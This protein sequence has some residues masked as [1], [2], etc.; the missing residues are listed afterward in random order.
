MGL[1]EGWDPIKIGINPEI[2][3]AGGLLL[4]WH[5]VFV[6]IGIAL[7]VWVAVKMADRVGFIEDDSYTIALVAVVAGIIGARVLFVAENWNLFSDKP[8]DVFRINEGGISIYGALIGGVV[9]AMLYNQWGL[10]VFAPV[11]SPVMF[12]WVVL[13][14]GLR[15]PLVALGAGLDAI[16]T[17]LRNG[18]AAP[19]LPIRAGLDAAAFGMILGQGIGRIGDIIN[20]EHLAKTTDLPWAVVYTHANSPSFGLAPQ[21]PAVAYEFLGDLIIFGLL[22]LFWRFYKRD[23]LVFFT[24]AF[25]YSAMRVG[26]S[27]L[28]LDKQVLW[29]F[30]MAQVIALVVIGISILGFAYCMRQPSGRRKVE[31]VLAPRPA[32]GRAQA[33]R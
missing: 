8:L 9:V 15:A 20:G 14:R 13:R 19:R 16:R 6:A 32:T 17:L 21:Q 28:R 3:H 10:M 26:T 25:L 33:R 7:G 31:P 2:A 22:F 27:A 12:M 23:G 18:I 5:G 29:E 4:T 11:I 24:Y 1:I 30:K